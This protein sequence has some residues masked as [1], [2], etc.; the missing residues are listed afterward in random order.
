MTRLF[1]VAAAAIVLA[2]SPQACRSTADPDVLAGADSVRAWIVGDWSLSKVCGGIAGRCTTD[3]TSMPTRYTFRQDGNVDGYRGTAK[4]FTTNYV[5]VDSPPKD[6]D[7]R[8]A[9][10]IGLG[11]AVDPMPLKMQFTSSDTLALDQG[12]CDRYVFTYTRLR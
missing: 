10:L 5:I 1:G 4:L 2:A 6:S 11:P 12:C 9:L 8:P 7:N 3:S